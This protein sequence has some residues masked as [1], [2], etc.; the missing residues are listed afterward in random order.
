[1]DHSLLRVSTLRD[2]AT[3][4]FSLPE[5]QKQ[6]PKLVEHART[7]GRMAAAGADRAAM[8][9]RYYEL[10]ADE[11]VVSVR[12]AAIRWHA[13]RASEQDFYRRPVVELVDAQR[14]QGAD[15]VLLSGSFEECL[16]P[17]A[18]H[19]GATA[20]LCT[21]L[22]RRTERF[23]GAVERP[24]IGQHKAAAVRD[25]VSGVPHHELADDT[26]IG[27][28]LSDVPVLE[29]VGHP[30]VVPVDD[31]LAELARIRNWRLAE[32]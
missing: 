5:R 1:V 3:F 14:A 30:V 29:L 27:D 12:H 25:F 8:N 32:L 31:D 23:T 17:I 28:H 2:F 22:V 24:M 19:V 6:G 16:E 7:L 21:S 10:W 18:R 13:A 15:I 20:V 9:L 4:Y 26:A 11:P